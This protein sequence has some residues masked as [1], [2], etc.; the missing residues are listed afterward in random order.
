MCWRSGQ[1]IFL[2]TG[3][4][5]AVLT[6]IDS[7]VF[8]GNFLHN[9]SI[10]LQIKSAAFGVYYRSLLVSHSSAC[11]FYRRSVNASGTEI[12]QN[13]RVCVAVVLRKVVATPIAIW[14]LL[15]SQMAAT[16]AVNVCRVYDIEKRTGQS[17]KYLFPNYET[18]HWYAAVELLKT[19]Q[20]HTTHISIET[21]TVFKP[22]KQ[23]YQ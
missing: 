18:L 3:W 8:G 19:L 10:E 1:T 13:L 23:R 6:P 22:K 20:G 12:S 4:I 15:V 11:C 17:T 21:S 9:Y 7:L 14:H 2:P 5:H 16:C